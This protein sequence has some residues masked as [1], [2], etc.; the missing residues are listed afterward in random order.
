MSYALD[1]FGANRKL[2]EGLNAEVEYQTWELQ[3]A[4]LMLAGNVV[5]AAIR[6]AQ[7]RSQIDITR[8]L[9]ALQQQQLTITEK[10][11]EAGGL[12]Q[13]HINQQRTLVEETR[14][15]I[16]PLQQQLDVVNHQLATLI[17]KTP[18]DAHI[19]GINLDSLHLP[20][21]LPVSLPS[22]LVRQRPT[23]AQPSP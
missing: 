20:E 8:Q 23:S 12:P 13:Y 10:R 7:L 16:P 3:A 1:I 2:I 4:R 15:S 11:V 21:K 22:S 5:S 9:L 19:D 6:Q 18:A 14:A 17:G